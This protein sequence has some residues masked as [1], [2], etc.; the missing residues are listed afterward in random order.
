M[1]QTQL[2][3]CQIGVVFLALEPVGLRVPLRLTKSKYQIPKRDI[4]TSWLKSDAPFHIVLRPG[5]S[6]IEQRLVPP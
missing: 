1:Q 3:Q 2:S 4:L 5:E 6:P